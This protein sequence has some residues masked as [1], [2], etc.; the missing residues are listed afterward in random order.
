MRQLSAERIHQHDE[1]RSHYY[2]RKRAIVAEQ[3]AHVAPEKASSK[4]GSTQKK[5]APKGQETR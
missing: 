5:G 3:G 4:K 2:Y 1:R